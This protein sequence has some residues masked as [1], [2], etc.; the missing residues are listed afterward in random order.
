MVLICFGLWG[1]FFVL[2]RDG[3][4]DFMIFFEVVKFDSFGNVLIGLLL[5][6]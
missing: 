2:N 4:M 3:E 1:G 5:V 6:W